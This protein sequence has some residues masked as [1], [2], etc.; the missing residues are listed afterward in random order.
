LIGQQDEAFDQ[1]DLRLLL[2]KVLPI[3]TER[4][5]KILQYTYF[6]NKSQ[7]ETGDLLDISQMHV[8]RIQRRALLKLR[9]ALQADGIG[10]N[11]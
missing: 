5:Q 2:E 11:D 4:E 1:T 9:E 7:K 8:S 6:E 3:L 10:V